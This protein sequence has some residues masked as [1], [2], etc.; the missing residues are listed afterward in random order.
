MGPAIR[1]V[2]TRSEG[3]RSVHLFAERSTV[4]DV[5]MVPIPNDDAEWIQLITRHWDR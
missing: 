4:I 2:L 3:A 5:P 1:L